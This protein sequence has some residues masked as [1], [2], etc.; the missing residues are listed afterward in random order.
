VKAW[1]K[2]LVWVDAPEGSLSYCSHQLQL[3][4]LLPRSW[5]PIWQGFTV[6]EKALPSTFKFSDARNFWGRGG[7]SPCKK[8]KT[9]KVPVHQSLAYREV[10]TTKYREAEEARR[11]SLAGDNVGAQRSRAEDTHR[12]ST[13]GHTAIRSRPSRPPPTPAPTVDPRVPVSGLPLH[14][15]GRGFNCH[16]SPTR[17][18]RP[19]ATAECAHPGRPLRRLPG[20][21]PAHRPAV[22]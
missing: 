17:R 10:E 22:I 5:P 16:R 9:K 1:G 7:N 11:C 4:R 13:I 15:L 6:E 19:V 20:L 12:S 14:S 21:P 18:P 3:H 8:E 2:Q